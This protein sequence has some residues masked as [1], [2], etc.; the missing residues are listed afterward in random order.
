LSCATTTAS[1][2]AYVYFEDEQARRLAVNEQSATG[3]VIELQ[4]SDGKQH[5]LSFRAKIHT[6]RMGH[7]AIVFSPRQGE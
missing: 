5:D 4:P 7:L 2:L 6:Y 3:F 1:R